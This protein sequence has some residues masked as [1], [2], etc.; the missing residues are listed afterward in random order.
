LAS[1]GQTGEHGLSLFIAERY[2]PS[3]DLELVQVDAARASAASDQA[4]ED[5]AAVRY[6]GSTLIP[7]DETCFVLFEAPS[8]DDVRRLLERARITYDR[9]VEAVQIGAEERPS[10]GGGG[11]ER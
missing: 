4:T 5:G 10:G 8:A 2:V 11:G 6:L 3:A 9:L 1:S 7:G